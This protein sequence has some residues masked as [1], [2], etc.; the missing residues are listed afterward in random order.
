MTFQMPSFPGIC[1]TTLCQPPRVKACESETSYQVLHICGLHHENIYLFN[2]SSSTPPS[3]HSSALAFAFRAT[4]ENA[5]S[6][7]SCDAALSARLPPSGVWFCA[8]GLQRARR[9]PS[10]TFRNETWSA[11]MI[12]H[13]RRGAKTYSAK[14]VNTS[15]AKPKTLTSPDN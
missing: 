6:F 12:L 2:Q 3:C 1:R 11:A 14:S 9:Y 7:C 15:S 13:T 5:A 8:P 10:T 4:A